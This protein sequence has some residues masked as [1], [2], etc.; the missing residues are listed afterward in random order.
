MPGKTILLSLIELI[1]IFKNT[2]TQN[3]SL[4]KNVPKSLPFSCKTFDGIN[5]SRRI[6]TIPVMNRLQIRL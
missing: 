4:S 6:R 5:L 2:S 3:N 1:D